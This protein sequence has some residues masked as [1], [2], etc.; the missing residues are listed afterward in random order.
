MPSIYIESLGCP[1]NLVDSEHMI[2]QLQAAGISLCPTP[3]SA[4]LML[5]NT[6]G[7]I[8][9]AKEESIQTI[10]EMVEIKKN[11]GNLLIVT[12]C[13]TE[14]YRDNLQQEI[15]EIDGFLG[16][17][18]TGQ[19]VQLVKQLGIP[20]PHEPQPAVYERPHLYRHVTT[21]AH[22]AYVRISD[23]CN[24]PCAFC[25]IPR[26]RGRFR[27]RSIDDI[28]AETQHLVDRG[29]R[30]IMLIA[31][32]LNRYGYDRNRQSNLHLLLKELVSIGDLKWIRLMYTFPAHYTDDFIDIVAAEA[33]ICN[34]LDIP[35]QH[36]SD[37]L[38]RAM[39]RQISGPD[40]QQ[41]LWELRERIPGLVVRTTVIVGLPGEKRRHFNELLRFMEEYRFERLG[42]FPY[43]PEEDTPACG[44]SGQVS[45]RTKNR[46][47]D[48]LMV[49]QQAI[50]DAINK[51]LRGQVFETV[52]DSYD[53]QEDEW[54][55]RTYR[56]A[57]EIDGVV[58]IPNEAQELTLGEFYPVKIVDSDAYDLIGQVV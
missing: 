41:L 40:Q 33:K 34:Y 19:I 39:K 23:G 15:P 14:R 30:E 56:D 26:I 49:T 52:I 21:P 42:A 35:I 17:N 24:N 48:E 47:L 29:V 44:Y 20:L 31:Q 1:K 50:S 53:H 11:A 58:R 8:N 37:E 16:V 10:L 28:M 45:E 12:G 46:R 7:F 43:S 22:L 13:L 18:E 5:V 25:A 57:Y 3:D 9:P 2:G 54:I 51:E 36:I 27:S 6:C 4:D 38:L 32:D 55:G